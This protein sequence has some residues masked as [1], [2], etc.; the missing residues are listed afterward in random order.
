MV[1]VGGTGGDVTRVDAKKDDDLSRV[2]GLIKD[3]MC[4]GAR[5]MAGVLAGV[6]AM[7]DGVAAGTGRVPLELGSWLAPDTARLMSSTSVSSS[8]SVSM[9]RRSI[10]LKLACKALRVA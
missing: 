10:P 1:V 7:R 5:C 4:D 2:G 9:I 6:D 3:C 8:P